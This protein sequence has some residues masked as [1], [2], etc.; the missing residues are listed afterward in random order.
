MAALRFLKWT[1]R[2]F[3]ATHVSLKP[4]SHCF[5]SPFTTVV[6]QTIQTWLPL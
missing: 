6:Y 3:I 5:K 1:H 2:L 4:G